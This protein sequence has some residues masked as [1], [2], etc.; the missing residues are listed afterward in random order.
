MEAASLQHPLIP[1][2]CCEA[3][4]VRE[5]VLSRMYPAFP[6][7]WEEDE[8][9]WSMRAEFPQCISYIGRRLV[10]DMDGPIWMIVRT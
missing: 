4:V 6:H 7:W 8:M 10:A 3:A 9:V 2:N 1:V 5:E